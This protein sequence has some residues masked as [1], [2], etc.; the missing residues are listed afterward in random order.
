MMKPEYGGLREI[1]LKG[2]A[3]KL[4]HH[5]FATVRAIEREGD[6]KGV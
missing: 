2:L 1:A 4:G 5:N 3:R 6:D